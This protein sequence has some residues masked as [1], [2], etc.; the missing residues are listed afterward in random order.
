MIQKTTNDIVN[1]LATKSLDL[2][3]NKC[4]NAGDA[5]NPKDYVTLGQ[6]EDRIN[7]LLANPVYFNALQGKIDPSQIPANMKPPSVQQV[8]TGS[9]ALSTVYQNTHPTPLYAM[10]TI[11]LP[12]TSFPATTYGV[13]VLCDA[14]ASPSTTIGNYV[15][16]N[17]YTSTSAGNLTVYVPVTFIVLPNWY[18]NVQI[19]QA[20]P[21]IQCWTEW[22]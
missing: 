9:R 7:Q 16:T 4:I 1:K 5:Q 13:R 20:S 22:Y 3:G 21:V 10:V 19:S 12:T 17:S 6:L 2:H 11:Q 18:Y 15:I 8:V 14:N